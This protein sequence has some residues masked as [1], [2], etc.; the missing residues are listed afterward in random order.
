MNLD[1]SEDDRRLLL[2][3]LS[4]SLYELEAAYKRNVNFNKSY[5]E[6]VFEQIAC[7]ASMYTRIS[8]C[9]FIFDSKSLNDRIY[10]QVKME[11]V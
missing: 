10:G 9:E 7:Y 11:L 3:S 8:G 1:L 2:R 5:A 6:S 4:R